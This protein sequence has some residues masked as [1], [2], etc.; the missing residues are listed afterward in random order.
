MKTLA[1][2]IGGTKFTVAGFDG[3]RMTRR[4]SRATDR[5]GGREKLMESLTPLLREW[6]A[7][8][9]FDRC[10]IGFGAHVGMAHVVAGV[11][12]AREAA[13]RTL[14]RRGF[15]TQLQGVTMHRPNEPGYSR[16]ELFVLDDWR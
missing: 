2:D 1:I 4:E 13:Y 14:Q 9:R 5:A 16:P 15:R 12:T 10:G 3:E 8:E 6:H 11:N 7:A